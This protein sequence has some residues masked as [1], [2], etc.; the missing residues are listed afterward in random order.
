MICTY[1][2]SSLVSPAGSQSSLDPL[3]FLLHIY[4]YMYIYYISWP[5]KALF[6]RQKIAYAFT[7]LVFTRIQLNLHNTYDK[8][9]HDLKQSFGMKGSCFLQSFARSSIYLCEPY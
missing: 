9:M 6:C 4:L 3:D 1:I 8:M 7:S 2:H 5:I